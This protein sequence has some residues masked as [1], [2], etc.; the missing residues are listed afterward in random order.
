MQ[1]PAWIFSYGKK[2]K[3]N[4]VKKLKYLKHKKRPPSLESLN[5]IGWAG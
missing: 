3:N 1:S 4:V 5:N 2:L